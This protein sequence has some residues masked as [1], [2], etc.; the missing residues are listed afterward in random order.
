MVY[1][2]H[3]EEGASTWGF[4]K[5]QTSRGRPSRR[6]G[7]PMVPDAAHEAAQSGSAKKRGSPPW[8][9]E[10]PRVHKMVGSRSTVMRPKSP[11]EFPR[12]DA[13]AFR[14][15]GKLRKD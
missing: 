1:P 2:P 10:R 3:P 15:G 11:P 12:G 7:R 14:H 6:M 5:T 4:R 13:R 8:G 9:G